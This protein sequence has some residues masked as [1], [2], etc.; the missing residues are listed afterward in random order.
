MAI[1]L[2]LTACGSDA[3]AAG[4]P[5]AS[6]EQCKS[7]VCVAADEKADDLAPLSLACGTE[8][9][10]GGEVGARCELGEDCARGVCL[11]AGTC[12]LPC[13][14]DDQCAPLERCQDVFARTAADALQP[15]RACVPLVCL[16]DDASVMVDVREDAL[17]GATEDDEGTLMLPLDPIR[18]PGA[19]PT[20]WFVLE[21]LDDDTWPDSTFC[22]P[23]L[24]PITLR[25]RDAKRSVL[26][27]R[28]AIDRRCM[29]SAPPD[30]FTGPLNTVNDDDH[31]DPVVV[32]IPN[33]R[34][35]GSATEPPEEVVHEAGYEF[36]VS[37]EVAGDLRLTTIAFDTTDDSGGARTLDLTVY[38]IGI[39]PDE[40][41]VEDAVSV[42]DGVF[43][44]AEI[45]IGETRHVEV[46]GGLVGRGATFSDPEARG[47]GFDPVEGIYGVNAELPALM[48]LSAGA[49]EAGVNVFVVS[50]ILPRF[51]GAN[52]PLAVGGGIPG[53]PGMHGTGSSGIAIELAT[54]RNDPRTLAHEIGHHLGLFHTSEQPGADGTTACVF[55]PLPDT[56]ECHAD[57]NLDGDARLT[58]DEC[59]DAGADNLMFSLPCPGTTLS[60]QQAAVLR[61]S[62]LLGR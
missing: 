3:P 22:R 25:A 24:C 7:G 39:D 1:S 31:V 17:T 61:A 58:C 29:E 62:P 9:D 48:R 8:R 57:R 54:L 23:P 15:V 53:P 5:C 12:A 27:D 40:R 13:A 55:E 43:A 59:A 47:A 37:D 52:D 11:L 38:W 36:S 45:T 56:P 42:V 30:D 41:T 51:G 4:G 49:C 26:F 19:E 28:S 14:T 46:R 21:H 2:A 16:S 6:D 10:G 50:E 35:A 34:R 33:G 20:T 32:M 18:L 44:Q 60:P